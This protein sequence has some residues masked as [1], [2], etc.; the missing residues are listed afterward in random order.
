MIQQI[1]AIWSLVPLPFLNP[2]WTSG[3]FMVHVLLN[4]GLENFDH[5]FASLWDECNGTVAWTFFGIAFLW[6]KKLQH[7][8]YLMQRTDSFEKTLTLGKIAGRRR[9]GRQ[10]MRWF[11]GITDSMDMGLGKLWE[12]VM[13]RGL[14]CCGSWDL[15]E[16]DM[17]ERL[18][19]IHLLEI[20]TS[21][22]FVY[23]FS[24]E[25]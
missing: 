14:V 24:L 5:Y 15:K 11:D 4:P 20:L 12:L 25:L 3:K 13:D 18:N 7:V 19:W 17:T 8:G 1:L 6:D 9:R 16:S 22:F 2:T 21:D 23:I 10:R